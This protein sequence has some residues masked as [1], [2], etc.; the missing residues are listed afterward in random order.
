MNTHT[1]SDG[2][3]YEMKG[4]GDAIIFLHGIGG[5]HQMFAPQV[6][7][8]SKCYQTITVD[9]K[10]NG[11]SESVSTRHYLD[12]HADSIL[13]L[14]HHLKIDHAIFVGLSYGGIVTQAFAIQNPKKVKKMILIDSYANMFPRDASEFRLML[15]GG[16]VA[17]V[18][19]A[20]KKWVKALNYLSP[21]KRWHLAHEQ[22][23]SIFQTCR[24]KDVTIQ[25]ME[26]FGMNFTEELN[27]MDIPVLVIAGDMVQ[28]V[29]NKS[30]EIVENLVN[31]ELLVVKDSFDPTNLC[32]PEIVNEAI[33]E[34]SK[35]KTFG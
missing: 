24:A 21:Y 28:A 17:L 22:M 1:L 4:S 10:G 16:F 2:L 11:R 3:Y 31:G 14:M 34:F 15:L 23:L 12:V 8:L 9:L 6:D 32:Q 5:T 26:V 7:E 13:N 25:L 29:V 33:L 18:A 20:P 19:W 30:K 27:E 35:E